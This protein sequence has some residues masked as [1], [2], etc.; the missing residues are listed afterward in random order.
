MYTVN[1]L[2]CKKQYEDKLP[3]NYYCSEC[4]KDRKQFAAEIDRKF[5]NR[6]KEVKG[7]WQRYEEALQRSGGRF[8]KYK[9][10]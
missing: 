6:P 2:K 3:E 1:C 7:G 4:N 9:D 8:P 5:A 10:L